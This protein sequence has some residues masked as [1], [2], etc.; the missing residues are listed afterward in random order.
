MSPKLS[1]GDPRAESSTSHAGC[2]TLEPML[3]PCRAADPGQDAAAPAA[4]GAAPD[5]IC[6]SFPCRRTFLPAHEVQ[7]C[8]SPEPARWGGGSDAGELRNEG[9]ML[10]CFPG[11]ILLR[12]CAQ[13]GGTQGGT[14]QGW[15]PTARPPLWGA[16]LCCWAHAGGLNS[17]VDALAWAA[18]P[19]QS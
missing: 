9:K 15:F 18:S 17:R 8:S 19:W 14:A 6:S 16:Q 10:P 1:A 2:W 4:S 3:P 11:G 12:N 13:L 7:H 5:S